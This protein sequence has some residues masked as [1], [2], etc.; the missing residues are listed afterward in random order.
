MSL[1]GAAEAHLRLG[2]LRR[3]HGLLDEVDRLLGNGGPVNVAP[4]RGRVDGL[5]TLAAGDPHGA[6]EVLNPAASL[7]T[8]LGMRGELWRLHVAAARAH[9]LLGQ[10][11]EAARAQAAAR[12]TVESILSD[13]TDM[14]LRTK[15]LHATSSDI[16]AA[17]DESQAAPAGNV[18]TA[19]TRRGG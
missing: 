12:E 2:D 8:G 15:Y 14:D 7:A 11:L 17:A 19:D 3:C 18:K 9:S 1:I 5:A 16:S 13:M 10:D 4:A 6:L